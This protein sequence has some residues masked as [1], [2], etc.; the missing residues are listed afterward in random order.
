MQRFECLRKF[1]VALVGKFI[2]RVGTRILK[3]ISCNLLRLYSA[4]TSPF[5]SPTRIHRIHKRYKNV[6]WLKDATLPMSIREFI[7]VGFA[8]SV[9]TWYSSGTSPIRSFRTVFS[10]AT[11]FVISSIKIPFEAVAVPTTMLDVEKHCGSSSFVFTIGPSVGNLF[12]DCNSVTMPDSSGRH[13]NAPLLGTFIYGGL[14]ECTLF[15][16]PSCGPNCSRTFVSHSY[17]GGYICHFHDKKT[18]RSICSTCN[19]A[20]FPKDYMF[21]F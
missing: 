18:F 8:L 10:D 16:E 6:R 19:G 12:H 13:G 11:L 17:Q 20:R 3:M 7:E 21:H 2:D 1:L 14:R 4:P 15:P 9:R 5:L